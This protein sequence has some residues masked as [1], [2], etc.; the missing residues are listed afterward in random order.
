[1]NFELNDFHRNV[2]DQELVDDLKYVADL[3]KRNTVTL[4][5]YNEYGHYHSTTLT[6]RFGSWFTCLELAGLDPSRSKIGISNIE[7][8]ED[9]ERIWVRLGK[10]PS[11]A[12]M[13]DMSQYSIGTY[14]KRFGGWRSALTAFVNYINGENV[15][16]TAMMVKMIDIDQ[17]QEH[18]H[19]TPRSIN[20]R[21]R[22]CVF[23]R[24]HFKCCICG[25]SPAKD[26]TVTLHVDH[27]KPWSSGGETTLDNL[28]TLC[29]KCNLGKG[30]LF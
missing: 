6:R 15:D 3:I 14:E 2:P 25:A 21:L 16:N 11:Y 24:D 7:L 17:V 29:S 30:D 20:L 22:F 8:F 4:D 12:Q 5:E 1:M 9:I 28:Q 18:E 13:R 19:K 23:Q 26:P 27:V 10:Q